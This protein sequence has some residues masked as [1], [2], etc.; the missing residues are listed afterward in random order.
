M[1][2]AAIPI[3]LGLLSANAPAQI[4]YVASIKPNHAADART[5]SEYLPGGRLT[6]TAITV[7]QLLRIAYRVQP[8]QLAGAPGW[9]STER[10]DIEAKADNTP[11]PSQQA[12]LQALLKGRFALAAHNETREMPIL[13]L[14]LARKDG[15]LGPRL[16][17][18]DF[19]CAA[20]RA[21]AHALPEPGRTPNCA[22]RIGPGA[23][24]GKAI[25]MAQ[26]VT[27]LAPLASRFTVDKTGL[28]GNFDV[29]LQWTSDPLPSDAAE[30]TGPSLF[31]ALQEQLGLK[32][33]A[34]R[35]PV[36]V[37]VI[38]RLEQPSKN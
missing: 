28:A 18:S 33:V 6:A 19:D 11:P 29:E 16:T 14:T 24:S 30:S 2:I 7:A 20:W 37:L 31:T 17:P 27:G 25:S 26:L 8:Y 34:D 13:T 22:T 38:D 3:T 5:F 23:L 21:V 1:K 10:F 32:L 15:K 9:I 35:G 12:L 36:D 4:S